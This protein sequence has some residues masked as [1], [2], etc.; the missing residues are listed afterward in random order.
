MLSGLKKLLAL[1]QARSRK[2]TSA[3]H[4]FL[5][6]LDRKR[7]YLL[8]LRAILRTPGAR[9]ALPNLHKLENTVT[10][11]D[12][13]VRIPDERMFDLVCE[14]VSVERR[15]P[16]DSPLREV[17]NAVPGLATA[18]RVTPTP[19]SVLMGNHEA[20]PG[21]L[22]TREMNQAARRIGEALEDG[23]KALASARK[24]AEEEPEVPRNTST[25]PGVLVMDTLNPPAPTFGSLGAN[26][27]MNPLEQQR[28]LAESREQ[29]EAAV[30][31]TSE[32]ADGDLAGYFDLCLMSGEYEKVIDALLPRVAEEPTAWAWLR[33]L[34]AA[35][36]AG[37]FEL[38]GWTSMF[39]GWVTRTHPQLLPDMLASTEE[40]LLFGVRRAP[41]E[42][43]AQR[44]LHG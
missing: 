35:Q 26:S 32:L 23:T 16:A 12:R 27:V 14:L 8:D 33:L 4:I 7:E 24:K 40:D 22:N 3:E 36:A 10:R 2:Q 5:L 39:R 30:L 19:T 18:I 15:I 28:F 21:E 29:M 17:M 37:K 38:E 9:R 1:E 11:N 44:E 20:V 34:K 43:L 25:A 41:L 13:R 42:E 31:R 6:D